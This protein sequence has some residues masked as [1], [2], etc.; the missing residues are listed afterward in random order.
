[1]RADCRRMLVSVVVGV[2]PLSAWSQSELELPP[3]FT[4]HMVIQREQPVRFWGRAEAYGKVSVSVDSMSAS[5]TV[6]DDGRWEIE[7]PSLPAGG[8]YIVVVRSGARVI[9]IQDVMVGD[10]WICSGQSNMAFRL[11]E[12]TDGAR[13]AD[14]SRQPGQ[15]GLRF[16]KFH[17]QALREPTEAV[18]SDGWSRDASDAAAQFSAVG[19]HFGRLVHAEAGVP[20]GLIEASW[21]GT[22][23]EAWTPDWALKENPDWAVSILESI[24]MFDLSD[25]EMQA[26]WPDENARPRLHRRPSVLYNGMIH[27][28]TKLPVRGVIWYQGEGNASRPDEY[29]HLFP[30]M[31]ESWRTAWSEAGNDL[32]LPFYFVQLPGFGPRVDQPEDANWARLRESQAR[33]LQLPDTG[34]AVAID[35]GEADDIHP[36]NKLPIGQRLAKIALSGVYGIGP[37]SRSPMY[38]SFNVDPDGKVLIRVDS[39]SALTTSDGEPPIGFAIAGSD[40]R[41]VWADARLAEEGIILH[42]D[43]VPEPV[44]VR[45]AWAR[46]PACNVV[47]ETGLPL[48]PFRTDDWEMT[49]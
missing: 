43:D 35:V 14:R 5:V 37:D 11:I 16:F 30:T 47:D 3:L 8:P 45:Y 31:I 29:A 49:R 41:F 1:M 22:P 2:L 34:M 28:L 7:L 48:A 13:F 23:A 21:G 18:V 12:S 17:R 39:S 32:S 15:D 44:A 25:A 4:D 6:S 19:Y 36:R 38:D 42:S 20:I 26:R 10:V 24:A 9:S 33:T 46:N 40:R 27:P